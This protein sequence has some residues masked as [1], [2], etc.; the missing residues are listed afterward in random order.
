MWLRPEDHFTCYNPVGVRPDAPLVLLL[1]WAGATDRALSKYADIL[2]TWG[3]PSV[4]S[5]QPTHYLFSPIDWPRRQWTLAMLRLLRS[6]GLSPP[7]PIIIYSFSNGGGFVVEQLHL[8]AETDPDHFGWL[9]SFAIG[10]IYDSS[11]CYMHPHMGPRVI[12][13]NQPPGLRREMT[14]TT[15][16][17]M[18]KL[19]PLFQAD[20]P[21]AY[22]NRMLSA[23]WDRPS[24]FLFSSD[25]PLCDAE[26]LQ[27]L[28]EEKQRRGQ[29]VR[30]RRWEESQ[31][32]AHLKRHKDEY[33]E[34]LKSFLDDL[35]NRPANTGGARL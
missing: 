19:T 24:L 15:L 32:C 22:W 18:T 13:A 23:G 31:H 8:L 26:R 33:L 6:Q 2:G 34:C 9:R 28:I 10:Y 5:V 27:S 29:S 30:W 1:G 35:N 7:R 14:T 3:Y 25:D 17:A 21:N 4:R 16:M 12:A 11:P 20:R